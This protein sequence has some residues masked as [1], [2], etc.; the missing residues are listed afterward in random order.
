MRNTTAY[1]EDLKVLKAW[2]AVREYVAELAVEFP[3]FDV[4]KVVPSLE[5]DYTKGKTEWTV[6]AIPL[7]SNL[8]KQ[9]NPAKAVLT[10]TVE[11]IQAEI[12][13][14]LTPCFW[15]QDETLFFDTQWIYSFDYEK[16]R[17]ALRS[18]VARACDIV[19]DAAKKGLVYETERVG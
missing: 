14:H 13:L 6:G 3:L 11:R 1:E 5:L 8:Q 4:D 19:A 7:N 2:H 12:E 18:L 10:E 17:T 9:K 16:W 15:D